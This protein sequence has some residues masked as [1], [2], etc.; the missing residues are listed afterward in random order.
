MQTPG[1]DLGVLVCTSRELSAGVCT[2][3]CQE[4]ESRGQLV[5]A[6]QSNT[7]GA[8]TI[9]PVSGNT[10]RPGSGGDPTNAGTRLIKNEPTQEYIICPPWMPVRSCDSYAHLH[11]TTT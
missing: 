4:N 11:K 5:R 1:G 9:H 8:D 3:A 10:S 7:D 6:K 2:S